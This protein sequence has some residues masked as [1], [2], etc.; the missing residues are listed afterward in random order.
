MP[1]TFPYIH[2]SWIFGVGIRKNLFI[3]TISIFF[4]VH[5]FPIFILVRFMLFPLIVGLFAFLFSHN[6]NRVIRFFIFPKMWKIFFLGGFDFLSGRLT[7][8]F[9]RIRRGLP[10]RFYS[11]ILTRRFTCGGLFRVL[12]LFAHFFVPVLFFLVDVVFFFV[13][14]PLVFFF[15]LI[16]PDHVRSL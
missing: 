14:L 6:Q 11:F 16:T 10:L 13:V 12:L 8:L 4:V 15:G 7:G 5:D 9:R 2:R 1:Y 3:R